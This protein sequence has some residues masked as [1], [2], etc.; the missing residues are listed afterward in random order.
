M[1]KLAKA[2]ALAQDGMPMGS[3]VLAAA[4]TVL[5]GSLQPLGLGLAFGVGWLG[6][7][8]AA[9]AQPYRGTGASAP[10]P[11]DKTPA[12]VRQR[13]LSKARRAALELAL[14]QIQSE[15]GK[16]GKAEKKSVLS[17]T[18]AWTGAYRVLSETSEGESVAVEIEVEIDVARLRKKVAGAPASDAKPLFAL[19]AVELGDNCGDRSASAR[20]EDELVVG[21]AVEKGGAPLHVRVTCTPLGPVPHTFVVAARAVLEAKSEGRVVARASI[22]SFG[23]DADSAMQA[24]IA[25]AA[26]S[27]AASAALHRR[28]VVSVRVQGALPAA[29]MRRFERALVQSVMGVAKVELAGVAG[30][31]NV[32]LSVHG[33]SDAPAL[34]QALGSFSA[35][36]VKARVLAVE[37]PDALAIQ[38]E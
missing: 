14:G 17:A 23:G 33:P 36:G 28:G 24:A 25:E 38:L 4:L 21:H 2:N 7:A 8:P 20:V 1:V 9:A 16:I 30:K 35:P 15:S 22:D 3:R 32:L 10:D 11:K 18:D 13:A 29:R 26:Q 5:L 19:E 37:G 31:G 27:V 12:A 6:R 34:A